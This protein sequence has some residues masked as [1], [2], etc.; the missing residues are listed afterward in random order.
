MTLEE[1]QANV[2]ARVVYRPVGAP[3]EYGRITDVGQRYV[4]VRY[5]GGRPASLATPADSLELAP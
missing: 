1:A 2:G 3:V 5:E 4:F